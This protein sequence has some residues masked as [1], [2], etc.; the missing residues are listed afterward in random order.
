MLNVGDTAPDIDAI[1]TDG[2]RFIL[3]AQQG[4]ISVVYFFPRAFT[5]GCT[6]E[7][8]AFRDDYTELRLAGANLVGVSTDD[9]KTQCRFAE[10]LHLPFPLIADTD[11]R[12]SRAW[13]VLFPVVSIARRVTFVLALNRRVLAVFSH[14]LGATRHRDEV[15]HF[16]EQSRSVRPPS[17]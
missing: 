2:S 14:H 12:I 6:A 13:G 1:A 9:P 10:S 5:P 16:V 17:G 3:S 7:T 8:E 15:L 4:R 11:A